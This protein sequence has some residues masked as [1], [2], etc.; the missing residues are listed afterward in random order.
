MQASALSGRKIVL[1]TSG[2]A[3]TIC[4]L[5]GFDLWALNSHPVLLNSE[6]ATTAANPGFAPGTLPVLAMGAVVFLLLSFGA[7][8]VW[9]TQRQLTTQRS[10]QRNIFEHTAEA[11]LVTDSAQQIVAVNPAFERITGYAAAEVL[12]RGAALFSA[13][14]ATSVGHAEAWAK[15]A[16]D[17]EWQGELWANRKCGEAYPAQ[18]HIRSIRQG[19]QVAASHFVAMFSDIG[20]QK[21]QAS[22]I[23]YLAQHDSLT[24]LLNRQAMEL[25]LVSLLAV[26]ASKAQ[27][28][29][30]LIIDLDNFKTVN[31]SLGH[32][33]GDQLLRE[34]AVRLQRRLGPQARLF[35]L[36]GDEFVVVLENV[37]HVDCVLTL[38]QQLVLAVSEPCNINGRQLHI[39]ASIGISLCPGDGEN[40]ETLIRNADTALYFAKAHGRNNYQF[41]AEPMNAAANK[42]L[43]MES[44]LWDALAEDQLVLHYQPQIDLLSGHVVGVEALVRW[45]HPQRGLIAPADFIPVAEECGLILT[46]GHWVLG[47]A[48]RQ[49]KAWLDAG[50]E[51]G[52]IAVNIS[53]LQFRQPQFTESV[54]AILL[55]T[56]LPAERLELEIT[57]S[58]VM[59][60]ADSSAKV[61]AE[62][63]K[64]GVKLAIDDFGTGYSSLSYLRRF[65]VDR[66]KIDRSFVADVESDP[67][68]ASLV[69]S[70]VSLG[71]TLGLQLVAEGVEN[72]AQADFLRDR[73]CQR[74]QGFHFS[75]P[76]SAEAVVALSAMLRFPK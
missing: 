42:R 11:M 74:V 51:L 58:T 23:D 18:I 64:M 63:K 38:V 37:D 52:E 21:A 71:G 61:L 26:T 75:R 22:R 41:F 33:A 1:L 3:A 35:R 73:Q 59:M 70:I 39:N 19:K 43:S 16:E 66:L 65:P 12:G 54:Q 50:L 57:E 62:L 8:L 34:M 32:Q 27:Q 25:H 20:A 7:H 10:L 49:A 46:L 14:P 28:L 36:G 53:A 40:A 67:D 13:D 55:E 6:L 44:E 56:G 48:C 31:D 60:S 15:V 76:V 72:A 47:T 9:R 4:S 5:V 2:V 17:G 29:A 69:A 68:A 30:V 45:Q 24:G